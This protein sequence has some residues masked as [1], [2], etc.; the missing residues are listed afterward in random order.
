MK[1]IESVEEYKERIGRR[2]SVLQPGRDKLGELSTPNGATLLKGAL[3]GKR[4]ENY[5]QVE[6]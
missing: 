4:Y 2:V 3:L 1:F 5:R 6:A